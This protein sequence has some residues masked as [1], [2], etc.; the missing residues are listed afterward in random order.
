MIGT[1]VIGASGACV[2]SGS[3]DADVDRLTAEAEQEAL[4]RAEQG[5]R[6][7]LAYVVVEAHK[8]DLLA[9]RVIDVVALEGVVAF[10]HALET[11][12]EDA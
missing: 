10:A 4:F 12:L 8:G 5:R 9:H 11:I 3:F 7:F 1:L 2:F 6:D